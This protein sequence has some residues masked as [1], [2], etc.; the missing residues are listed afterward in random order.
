MSYSIQGI[1]A[2]PPIGSIIAYFGSSDPPGWVICNGTVRTNGSDGRYSA[3][4]TMSIGSG[5]TGSYTPPDLRGMFLRG[6]GTYGGSGI[7]IGPSLQTQQT[8]A[9]KSHT[10][11]TENTFRFYGNAQGGGSADVVSWDTDNQATTSSGGDEARPVNIG[12]NYIIK[13]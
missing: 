7:Y 1:I 12:V 10:H 2:T 8:D 6:T 11:E 13:L 5:T 9:N 3:L 4:L